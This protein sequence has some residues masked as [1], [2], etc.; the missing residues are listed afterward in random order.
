MG[1]MGVEL[2]LKSKVTYPFSYGTALGAP[3]FF[4]SVNH[5]F[6]PYCIS[7]GSIPAGK[8]QTGGNT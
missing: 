4:S 1:H 7:F 8:V 2:K 3:A 5:H 6:Y